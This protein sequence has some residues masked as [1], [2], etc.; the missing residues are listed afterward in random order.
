MGFTIIGRC[1]KCWHLTFTFSQ[2]TV[3][4]L[5]QRFI[6]IVR[7]FRELKVALD[8]VGFFVTPQSE[9]IKKML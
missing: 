6:Y 2:D 5:W 3:K 1:I 8:K 4:I 9:G 7:K